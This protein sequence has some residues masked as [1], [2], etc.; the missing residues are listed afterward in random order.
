MAR[1]SYL[2]SFELKRLGK[3]LQSG[4]VFLDW[5]CGAGK[6][7]CFAKRLLGVPGIVSVGIEK[8]KPIYDVCKKNLS[9][10]LG[11]N[12]LHE[13]SESFVSFCPARVAL[14]YDGGTQAMQLSEKGQ[15]HPTVMMA[16]FCSPTID[17]VV[18]TRVNSAAFW[19][20]FSEHLDK[21]CGSLWKCIYLDKCNFGGS[22]FIANVW[23][24][25]SP[26]H[27]PTI[28]IEKRMQGLL[29]G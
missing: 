15:I 24:R 23:F 3:P 9:G 14:N 28:L 4:D 7:L 29:A 25:I 16:A 12:V 5:G 10:L 6:W 8:E 1:I 17:V 20:Y 22:K 27:T 19:T 26:M 21:F 13:R 2:I 11:C 18:S